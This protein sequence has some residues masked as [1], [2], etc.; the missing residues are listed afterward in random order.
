MTTHPAWWTGEE[1]VAGVH[2][3]GR[4]A[5]A[6]AP[7]SPSGRLPFAAMARPHGDVTR[8]RATAEAVGFATFP[9]PSTS[10]SPATARS[11]SRTT[12][13]DW[14]LDELA[15]DA[16]VV[17][18]ELVTNALRYGHPGARQHHPLPPA[19]QQQPFLLSLVHHGPAVLCAVFDPGRDV[20][21]MK[22]PDYFQES[23]RGLHVLQSLAESWGWTT[24]DRHGK[25]VWALLRS[26]R[27]NEPP[28][29]PL[30]P[31]DAEGEPLTRLLLLLE[32]LS[33]PSWLK[34]L[35]ASAM[36]SGPA[37][38]PAPEEPG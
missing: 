27:R 18:S 16:T 22:E 11:L 26:V 4:R 14:G 25:A 15:D 13:R 20:P 21:E 1:A 35:G 9:L 3:G 19:T 38:A 33:G 8:N 6:L 7:L 31:A 34:A 12:L 2:G 10:G 24:P 36:G 29:P 30:G 23:G 5:T 17:V 37:P 28:E 32:L